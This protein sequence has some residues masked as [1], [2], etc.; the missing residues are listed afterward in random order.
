MKINNNQCEEECNKEQCEWDGRDC[1]IK[2]D[3]EN[4]DVALVK[5]FD[6]YHGAIFHTAAL[7]N[8]AYG[9]V[10][11]LVPA[12]VPHFIDR[13]LM[14]ELQNRYNIRVKY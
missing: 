10:N 12:H 8:A 3:S 5:K 4:V 2:N 11:R 13:D 7:F 6:L 1:G 9:N 14:T